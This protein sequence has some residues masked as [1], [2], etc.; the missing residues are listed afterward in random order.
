[1][2][3]VEEVHIFDGKVSRVF[4]VISDFMS[5]PDVISDIVS[6]EVIENKK[7]STVVKFELKIVKNFY[8]ILELKEKKNK[9]ISWT[10]V[11]SDIMKHNIGSWSFKKLDENQ[12]QATYKIDVKFGLLVPKMIINAVVKGNLP[13][14]F[15]EFNQAITSG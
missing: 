14:M 8:Y 13:Q 6:A 4:N 12:T 15:Q 1:M 7:T 3:G 9:E 11:E 2:A 5:Y 10:L